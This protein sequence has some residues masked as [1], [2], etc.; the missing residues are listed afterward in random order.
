MPRPH[1]TMHKIREI[2][3]LSHEGLS[4]REIA[5]S[6]SV[7][8]TTV[9]DYLRRAKVASIRWPLDE[10]V[11]DEVLRDMLFGERPAPGA[12]RPLPDLARVHR[13]LRRN[14]VTLLLLWH[15][16]RYLHKNHYVEIPIM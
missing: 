12:D 9:C 3:R 11:D 6:M 14:G 4:Q 1:V 16:C 5:T 2:L 13:E 15:L 8:K 7:P 10:D